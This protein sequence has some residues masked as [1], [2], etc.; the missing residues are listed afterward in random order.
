MYHYIISYVSTT[1]LQWSGGN[2][3]IDTVTSGVT[4]PPKYDFLILREWPGV[5]GT[6]SEGPCILALLRHSLALR[7]PPLGLSVHVTDEQIG[8]NDPRDPFQLQ[9]FTLN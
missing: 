7:S 9:H 2:P 3:D 8:L 6:C 4:L 5:E 1:Y